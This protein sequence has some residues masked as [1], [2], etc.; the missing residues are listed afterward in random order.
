[1]SSA[2]RRRAAE[3]AVHEAVAEQHGEAEHHPAGTA[4]ARIVA[5]GSRG[6][7]RSGQAGRERQ[8][9]GREPD[10][11]GGGQRQLSRQERVGAAARCRPSG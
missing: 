8:D 6:R 9:E 5:R 1:M 4:N 2:T 10:R 7:A 11:E 3:R